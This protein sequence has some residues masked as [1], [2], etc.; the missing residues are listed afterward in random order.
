MTGPRLY[1]LQ[2]LPPHVAYFPG[3]DILYDAWNKV[4]VRRD[5]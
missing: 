2:S 5:E 1:Y 4:Y 3:E